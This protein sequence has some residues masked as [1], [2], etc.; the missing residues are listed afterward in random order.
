MPFAVKIGQFDGPL[1]LLLGLIEE[2]RLS[3]SD[4]SLSK[5]TDEY[6]GYVQKFEHYPM[7]E[8]SQFVLV[9]ATLLLI[10]S[11]SL[12]PNMEL[13]D[14]EEG[15]I[16]ELER[17]LKHY[18]IIRQGARLLLKEWGTR[19]LRTPARA[20]IHLAPRFAPGNITLAILTSAFSALINALPTAA[21]MNTVS[22]E[23]TITL[24]DMIKKLEK[25]IT[26]AV[27]LG[28]RELT[29]HANKNEVVIQFLAVLELIR[30]GLVTARQEK[31][32]SDIMLES[33]AV[34]TPTYGQ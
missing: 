32:F 22:I 23:P 2:R 33:D 27:R 9:A 24:E 14:E 4:I 28:F 29:K 20:P 16:K 11:R 12:L 18:K 8:V 25:R 17:R 3:V 30:N 21:F 34:K 6:L 31:T 13:T 15:D 1:D 10:K 5:V 26:E 7:H 19:P